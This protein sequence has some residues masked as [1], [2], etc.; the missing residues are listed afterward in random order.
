MRDHQVGVALYAMVMKSGLHQAPLPQMMRAVGSE[1]AI[2]HERAQRGF[3]KVRAR[4]PFRLP[5]QQFMHEA[6][7]IEQDMRQIVEAEACDALCLAGAQEGERVLPKSDGVVWQ[8]EGVH[9]QRSK[10]GLTSK[11]LA[12][13]DKDSLYFIT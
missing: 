13:E 1:Q 8:I 3:A 9:Q 2:A 4:K 12:R 10:H 11:S 5:D 6:R 7:I